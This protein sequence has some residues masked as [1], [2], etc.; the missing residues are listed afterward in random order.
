MDCSDEDITFDKKGICNHCYEF[1]EKEKQRLIEKANFPKIVEEIKKIG[2][3]KKYDCL[4]GLS[5]GVDS[6][7]CL[8]Y[9]I[10]LGLRPLTFSV[11]NGW[12]TPESDENIMRLVEGLKVPFERVVVD[13]EEFRKL[14]KAFLWA[15]VINAEIPTDHILMAITYKKAVE[16]G[17]K[18]IISGGNIATEAIMPR[19]WGYEA[20]DLTHIK[21][22]YK[23]Y[24]GKK[25]KKTPTISLWKYLL[26]RF[27]KTIKTINL[28]DY[29][30][31]N[32]ETAKQLLNEKYG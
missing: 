7:L 20:R 24:T 5:G 17:I 18:Y 8:H 16:N 4:L 10:E 12:N 25:L 3:D 9:L 26:Y 31:Y 23:K 6:S 22:I 32:R 29:Y 13:L 14:Q 15:S 28:L 30:E 11:D 21:A 1:A 19:S 2:R 27:G